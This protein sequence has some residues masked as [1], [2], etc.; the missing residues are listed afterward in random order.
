MSEM[1]VDP[2]KTY[3]DTNLTINDVASWYAGV[4]G[5]IVT[6]SKL[7]FFDGVAISSYFCRITSNLVALHQP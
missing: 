1:V 7:Y 5:T 4:L 2:K 6:V 3:K